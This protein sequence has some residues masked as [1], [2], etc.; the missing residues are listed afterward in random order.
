MEML[1]LKKLS[2]NP[3]HLVSEGVNEIKFTLDDISSVLSFFPQLENGNF[4]QLDFNLDQ[5]I[6][7]RGLIEAMCCVL[8]NRPWYTLFNINLREIKSFISDNN[9]DELESLEEDLTKLHDLARSLAFLIGKSLLSAPQG[10]YKGNFI[11]D[12]AVLEESWT[13]NMSAL[14]PDN[15]VKIVLETFRPPVIGVKINSQT[16]FEKD[17]F[18]FLCENLTFLTAQTKWKLVAV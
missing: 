12:L 5:N 15:S 18:E 17:V 14:F 2:E 9:A 6:S 3:S 16:G 10:T 13:K 11:E 8:S 4:K 7:F 1:R